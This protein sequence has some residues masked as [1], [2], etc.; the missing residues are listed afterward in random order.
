[1]K[2]AASA[3]PHDEV[4]KEIIPPAVSRRPGW[5]YS[6]LATDVNSKA[7]EAKVHGETVLARPATEHRD[8]IE[9][10]SQISRAS[11]VLPNNTELYS[12]YH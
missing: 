6:R 10:Y 2:R 11:A 9:L 4:N 1:M 5:I 8:D 7:T 3:I 12:I